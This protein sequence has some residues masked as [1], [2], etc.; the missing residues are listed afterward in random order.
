MP[1]EPG[2]FERLLSATCGNELERFA[3]LDGEDLLRL[4]QIVAGTVVVDQTMQQNALA[5]LGRAGDQEAVPVIVGRLANFD[6][7]ERINA[8]D[9]LGRLNTPESISAVADRTT[10]PSP[11]VRRF[12]VT[13]LSRAG[14]ALA[15]E[16]LN[17][18]AAEDPVDLVRQRA[19]QALKELSER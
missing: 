14:G 2:E 17:R 12:A 4:R 13:A 16:R 8:V 3:L 6:E 5:L 18:V 9:V 7:R 10:D 11:D 1:L 19:E 15:H